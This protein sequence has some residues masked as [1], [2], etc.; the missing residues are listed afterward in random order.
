[1]DPATLIAM[2]AAAAFAQP[3][4]QAGSREAPLAVTATVI[5]PVEIA[6]PAITADGAVL[7][8]RNTLGVEVRAAGAAIDHPQPDT[9]TVTADPSRAIEITIVH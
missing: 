2:A 4:G 5:R 8:I 3:P 1:M 6:S 9:V 7:T